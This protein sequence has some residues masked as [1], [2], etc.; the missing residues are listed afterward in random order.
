MRSSLR[1]SGCLDF[2]SRARLVEQRT[3]R[4]RCRRHRW[5][6]GPALGPSVAVAMLAFEMAA[7]FH[8]RDHLGLR[9]VLLAPEL[10]I[11]LIVGGARVAL[12]GPIQAV[13]EAAVVEVADVVQ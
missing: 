6:R 9:R 11:V 2:R 10:G 3:D 1:S 5:A 13:D 4:L 12:A 7:D 8:R